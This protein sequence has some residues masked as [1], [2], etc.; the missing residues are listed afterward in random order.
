MLLP[1]ITKYQRNLA[2]QPG[3]FGTDLLIH[4]RLH[5]NVNTSRLKALW[6]TE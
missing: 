2:N 5:P 6:Q 1:T 3:F 4:I